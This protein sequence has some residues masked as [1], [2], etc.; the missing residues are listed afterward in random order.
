MTIAEDKDTYPENLEMVMA[1]LPIFI[2]FIVTTLNPID[3]SFSKTLREGK[4][5][6]LLVF[7]EYV[8]ILATI[9]LFIF[10]CFKYKW[11]FIFLGLSISNIY[12]INENYQYWLVNT[13]FEKHLHYI[14][15]EKLAFPFHSIE[16]ILILLCFF[17]FFI[18]LFFIFKVSLSKL[19]L[20]I[21]AYFFSFCYIRSILHHAHPS[22]FSTS[23]ISIYYFHIFNSGFSIIFLALFMRFKSSIKQTLLFLFYLIACFLALNIIN[24]YQSSREYLFNGHLMRFLEELW[25]D[26]IIY[27]KYFLIK[28]NFL[29]FLI[30]LFFLKIY[31]I[32]I[33]EKRDSTGIGKGQA[34]IPE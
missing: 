32:Y 3:M 17:I 29:Y 10:K 24:I 25:A 31:S 8:M 11:F 20:F 15:N 5:S 13:F 28:S 1:V 19:F 27:T 21:F 22:I 7:Y 6:Q 12:I 14:I 4:W 16:Q 30:I 33:A 2:F 18:V 23:F 9:V 26:T 34:R